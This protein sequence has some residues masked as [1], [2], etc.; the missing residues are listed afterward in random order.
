MYHN[1]LK[2]YP[3]VNYK[4]ID[5]RITVLDGIKKSQVNENSWKSPIDQLEY[6]NDRKLYGNLIRFIKFNF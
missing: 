3:N 1:K 2:C 5:G 6:Q 4:L